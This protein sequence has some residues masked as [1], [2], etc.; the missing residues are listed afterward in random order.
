MF[1]TPSGVTR[2]RAAI[3]AKM[4]SRRHPNL[5][6]RTKHPGVF[7]RHNLTTWHIEFT[8]ED[9]ATARTYAIVFSTIGQDHSGVYDDQ[10]ARG[11]EWR[12][13][14]R[15]VRVDW[16]HKDTVMPHLLPNL[17]GGA[18]QVSG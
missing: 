15:R 2:C 5:I 9:T 4:T 12:F 13:A 11:R 16:I 18:A 8:G 3:L 10:L 17:E 7:T 6:D 1:E 14:H